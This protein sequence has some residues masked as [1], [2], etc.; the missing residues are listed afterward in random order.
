MFLQGENIARALDVPDFRTNKAKEARANAILDGKIPL[1]RKTYDRAMRVVEALE[2]FR[3]RTRLFTKGAP[4]RT[5]VWQEANGVW[6]RIRVDWLPDDPAWPL[7]DLKTTGGR[8]TASAW[9]EH[10]T[11][12]RRI[13]PRAS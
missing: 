8:A 10:V 7:A 2:K 6:C 13:S 3:D 11:I 9:D 5:L 4:E 12:M 1:R